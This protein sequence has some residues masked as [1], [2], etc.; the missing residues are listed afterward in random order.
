MYNPPNF[1]N[2]LPATYA[3]G[4]SQFNAPYGLS[5]PAM[6]ALPYARYLAKY[7]AKR[8]HLATFV[9][10]NRRN[11]EVEKITA[12]LTEL[13]DRILKELDAEPHPQLRLFDEDERDQRH[14]YGQRAEAHKQGRQGLAPG[15]GF[16][17][18]AGC[19]VRRCTGSDRRIHQWCADGHRERRRRDRQL[20][21]S[22]HLSPERRAW[23]LPRR[24]RTS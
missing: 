19:S 22:T 9:V 17:A 7:G 4:T 2:V 20:S 5:G 10:N 18:H 12:V 1:H 24:S 14:Q 6:F 13:R 16:R 23:S 11:D 3:P 21:G 15:S 8:E